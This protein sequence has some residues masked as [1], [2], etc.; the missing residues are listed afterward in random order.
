M[1]NKIEKEKQ[2]ILVIG[3]RGLIGSYLYDLL[4]KQ[5][6]K[7]IGTYF[8]EKDKREDLLFFD[9][10]KDNI[11]NLPLENISHGVI[12]AA[13]TKLDVCKENPEYSRKVNVE[14]MTKVISELSKRGIIPIYFSSASVFDGVKGGYKEEEI[15][16]RNP[17]SLYGEQKV[18][19]ENFLFSNIGDYL[20]V[21]PGKVFGLKED[22]GVLFAHWLSQ[23]KNNQEIKCADDEKLA[24]T[25]SGDVA[26]A[27]SFLIEKN[28]RG[29]WHINP[30]LQISRY[31][32]AKD[33]FYYLGIRDATIIKCS[34]DDLG[35]AEKRP[36]NTYTNADKLINLGFKFTPLKET[37]EMIKNV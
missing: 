36:K 21:R 26:R 6:K 5:N 20:I 15:Q 32:M 9:I 2:R 23:Y 10:T 28:A 8:E 11:D 14:F 22:E 17:T 4:K 25:F 16:E 29:I 1:E 12:C 13:V 33:F 37:F 35:L 3:A 18:E 31:N 27:I 7:V 34:I 19:V 30:N 24:P